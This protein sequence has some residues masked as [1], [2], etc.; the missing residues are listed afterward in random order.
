M[1]GQ[2]ERLEAALAVLRPQVHAALLRS[3]SG[4][5]DVSPSPASPL[6]Y[7]RGMVNLNIATAPPC[8][9]E[10]K[11]GESQVKL[12]GPPAA[13]AT[14]VVVAPSSEGEARQ[15]PILKQ[16]HSASSLASEASARGP[17]AAMQVIG[18]G[19]QG[20]AR[21]TPM[22]TS[23]NGTEGRRPQDINIVRVAPSF[24]D[25]ESPRSPG[26]YSAWK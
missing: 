14:G 23:K 25:P 21:R 15:A 16:A 6:R 2:I 20:E 13:S 5:G 8:A 19:G 18:G 12:L 4:D 17:G 3:S 9:M 1:V 11:G 7:R 22:G 24:A 10:G 26:K